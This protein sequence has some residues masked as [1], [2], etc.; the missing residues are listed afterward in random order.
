[1]TKAEL[2]II[3]KREESAYYEIVRIAEQA[4][5]RVLI[6]SS[7]HLTDYYSWE[8]HLPHSAERCQKELE[9]L[10]PEILEQGK[11]LLESELIDCLP[12]ATEVVKRKLFN[13]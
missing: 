11:D 9:K 7:F 5:L 3:A 8:K 4:G 13:A 1:M 6:M 12:M 10:S 2:D